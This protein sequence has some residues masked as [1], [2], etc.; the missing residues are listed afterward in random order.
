MRLPLVADPRTSENSHHIPNMP[1]FIMVLCL[2]IALGGCAAVQFQSRYD[3]ALG[4]LRAQ[5]WLVRAQPQRGQS[6]EQTTRDWDACEDETARHYGRQLALLTVHVIAYK[7]FE[8]C[9][10]ERGYALEKR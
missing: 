10:N 9:M 6:S 7:H 8:A 4:G 1:W 5:T 2:V 3:T